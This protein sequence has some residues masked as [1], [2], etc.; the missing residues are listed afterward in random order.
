MG[1]RGRGAGAHAARRPHLFWA[2]A[3]T[4]ASWTFRRPAFL[5]ASAVLA[6]CAVVLA[7]APVPVEGS[8]RL[9]QETYRDESYVRSVGELYGSDA[10]ALALEVGQAGPDAYL[11][12]VAELLAVEGAAGDKG[13]PGLSALLLRMAET[14]CTQVFSATNQMGLVPYLAYLVGALPYPLAILPGAVACTVVAVVVGR[15]SA[16]SRAP[17][18][19]RMSFLAL[20]LAGGACGLG[21]LAVALACGAAAAFALNGLGDPAY[22]VVRTVCGAVA[23]TSASEAAVGGICLLASSAAFLAVG[24]ALVARAGRSWRAVAIGAAAAVAFAAVVNGSQVAQVAGGLLAL[25]PFT[26][27][28]ASAFSGALGYASRSCSIPVGVA[29]GLACQAAW[30]AVVVAAAMVLLRAGFDVGRVE[31]GALGGA[32]VRGLEC[33]LALTAGERRVLA[34]FSA[35]AGEATVLRA[36]NGTGK[37]TLL[38]ALCADPVG[39]FAGTVRAFGTPCRDTAPFRREVFY[40]ANDDL[41]L[42]PWI[43]AR[44]AVRGVARMWG[45]D[46][47]RVEDAFGVGVFQGKRVSQMSFGMHQRTIL[48]C[49]LASGTRCLLLDEPS[50]GLDVDGRLALERALERKAASGAVL[51]VATHERLSV[52]SVPRQVVEPRVEG[53][54]TVFALPRPGGCWPGGCWPGDA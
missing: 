20:S 44:S 14:G 7:L 10:Q 54:V 42:P 4:V 3:A 34:A 24:G 12:K 11:P 31:K 35:A 17:V 53:G 19:P 18:S 26:Y 41:Q 23:V 51:V 5:A 50:C 16:A 13:A 25:L 48:T 1:G 33:D 22:P 40:A 45:S 29:E 47:A 52:G 15:G 46:A 49:A 38:R 39:G 28:D 27:F 2:Y 37:T 32:R 9:L 30:A 43:C 36:P 6:C 21:A 8:A